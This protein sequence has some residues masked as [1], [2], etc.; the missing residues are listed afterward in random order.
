MRAVYKLP[1][2]FQRWSF[3][4]LEYYRSVLIIREGGLETALWFLRRE[5][6]LMP[7]YVCIYLL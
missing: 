6:I 7:V 4:E 1:A 3:L 2:D 5:N